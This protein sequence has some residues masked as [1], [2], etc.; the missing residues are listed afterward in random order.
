MTCIRKPI[1]CRASSA[2]SGATMFGAV[3]FCMLGLISHASAEPAC[4]TTPQTAVARFLG[5]AGAVPAG[6]VV[7][8]G[9]RVW[10]TANDPEQKRQWMWVAACGGPARPAQLFSVPLQI[11]SR[12]GKPS[13][14][15]AV[16]QE[17]VHVGDGVVVIESEKDF[18]LRLSGIA[19]EAG[20]QGSKIHVRIPAWHNGQVLAGAVTGKDEVRLGSDLHLSAIPQP[21]LFSDEPAAG[22]SSRDQ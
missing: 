16:P 11:E 15:A 5:H 17:I 21:P 1:I 22:E 13:Y 4:S 14:A 12:S 20:Q 10:R 6:G 2:M 7:G 3:I 18:S 19:L 9:Y 8:Y